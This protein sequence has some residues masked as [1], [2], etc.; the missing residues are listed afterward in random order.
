MDT[1]QTYRSNG[2][3]VNVLFGTNTNP[4]PVTAIYPAT[5]RKERLAGIAMLIHGAAPGI[6][7]GVR[8]ACRAEDLCRDGTAALLPHVKLP[9]GPAKRLVTAVA[10]DDGRDFSADPADFRP[11]RDA[12]KNLPFQWSSSC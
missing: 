4:L 7:P 2:R 1:C 9:A 5:G 10:I 6:H 11:V 12:H 8:R 3:F